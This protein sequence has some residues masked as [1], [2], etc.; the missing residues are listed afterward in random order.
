MRTITVSENSFLSSPWGGLEGFAMSRIPPH[1]FTA[2]SGLAAN[3]GRSIR[4][5]RQRSASICGEVTGAF[6]GLILREHD[7]QNP[8]IMPIKTSS[9]ASGPPSPTRGRLK[10]RA[11]VGIIAH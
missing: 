1:G 9:T 8:S 2:R 7:L 10:A 5:A 4:A 6:A 11:T 3:G